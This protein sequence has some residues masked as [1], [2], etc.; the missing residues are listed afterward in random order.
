MARKPRKQSP[1]AVKRAADRAESRAIGDEEALEAKAE[2]TPLEPPERKTA[3]LTP[4]QHAFCVAYMESN[5]ASD[6]YR[7][8]YNAEGM[9]PAAVNVEASRLLDHPTIALRLVEMQNIAAQVAGLSRS[10]VLQRLMRNVDDAHS[11]EDFGA[12]TKAIELLGKTDE[13]RM[14]VERVETDNKHNHSVEPVSAFASFLA[15]AERAGTEVD[16]PQPLPN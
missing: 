7:K 4:K 10:W 16:S 6:A 14:F 1:E 8:A 15:E 13:M 5:N 9:S 11:K 2:K 3:I 12:S